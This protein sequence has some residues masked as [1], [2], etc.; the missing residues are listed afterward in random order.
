[1]H[2]EP[3]FRA[4]H[5]RAVPRQQPPEPRRVVHLLKVRN[6]VGG[7]V[8]EH[9]RRRQDQPPRE[10]ENARGR[11]GAPAACLIAHADA[12]EVDAHA[13]RIT[14][15]RRFH[16]APGFALEIVADPAR[17]MPRIAGDAQEPLAVLADLGPRRAA[18]LRP[19]RDAMRNAA[20]RQFAARRE[21]RRLRQTAQARGNPGAVPLRERLRLLEAAARR[22]GQDDLAGRRLDA[23]RIAACQ[24]VPA[25]PHQIDR[26]VERDLDRLRFLRRMEK[27]RAQP[28]GA[29]PKSRELCPNQRA[30]GVSGTTAAGQVQALAATARRRNRRNVLP[31]FDRTKSAMRGAISARKREPLNTP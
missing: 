17:Q 29:G 4:L 31:S 11:A 30:V 23:Q 2:V 28:H 6:L 12:P 24:S 10:R 25:Q 3:D 19:M 21:R 7:E 27:Q 22:H 8:V 20:Q 1:M 9:E 15:R 18:R 26:G 13:V 14:P 5:R 16:V